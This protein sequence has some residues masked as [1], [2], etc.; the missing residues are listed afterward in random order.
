MD[1]RASGMGDSADKKMILLGVSGSIAAYKACEL[2][3][4]LQND[5][6]DIKVVMTHHATE[7]VGAATFR[8]L[9]GHEV[10]LDLFE[11]P[12][13]PIHHISL[14]KEPDC[15]VVAPATANVIAKIAR[16]VADDLLTTT[17]LAYQGP[18]VIAPAM[19]DAMLGDATT[20]ENLETLEARGVRIVASEAGYLA[21][22]DEGAGRL[23]DVSVIKDA[24]IEAVER[25]G[26]LAGKH[27]V[28]TAGPTCEPIDAVRFIS[29]RS[30]GKMGYA[31]AHEALA[32]GA[33]VTLISGPVGLRAPKDA[34]LVAVRTADEMLEALNEASLDADIIICA[35]AVS[36]YR[37]ASTFDGKLKKGDGKDRASL[38]CVEMTENPDL[39][40]NVCAR[41]RDGRLAKS[42]IIVGFA[43]ET[44]NVAEN[45]R[46]KLASKGADF[47]VANDVSGSDTGFESD[48]NEVT[49]ISTTSEIKL[50]RTPKRIIARR[51]LDELTT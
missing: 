15:F 26:N 42:P 5:G 45:A 47:I 17:A 31:L 33:Q 21:C 11:D 36:D 13:K 25:S 23:A 7:L 18:L 16:G 28:I 27:L 34:Q 39:L 6:Y 9:T 12:S 50:D 8:A 2:V 20:Q 24:V 4:L 10:A 35:A 41:K 22:G 38:S 30:S 32:R 51:I 37:P 43:A 1:K 46:K 14:A 44:D 49:L 40:A 48:D 29:N 3:R 19:N